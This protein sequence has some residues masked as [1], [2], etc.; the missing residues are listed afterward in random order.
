[1]SAPSGSGLPGG[2]LRPSSALWG[3]GCNGVLA[4]MLTEDRAESSPWRVGQ[5]RGNRCK[6]PEG[7]AASSREPPNLS[8]A[9]SNLLAFL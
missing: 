9:R 5:M 8:R 2:A 7:S 6:R 1:M 3:M 4:D